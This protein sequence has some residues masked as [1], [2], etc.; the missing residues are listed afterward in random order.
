MYYEIKQYVLS[1]KQCQI[2]KNDAHKHNVPLKPLP[3]EGIFKRIHIDLFGPLNK[4]N[5]YKYV[6]LVV[7]S[8]TKWPEAFP[9]RTLTG[10]E[11]AKILYNEIICRWGAPY[12]LL[13]DRGTNFLSSIVVEVCKLFSISK[14]K[15]SSWHPETNATAERRMSTLAQTLRMYI[16]KHQTNWPDLLPSIMA[17]MRATPCVSSTLFSPY[18][19]LLGEEMRLPLDVDL[20]PNRTLP[21]NVLDR[22][23]NITSQFRV[24]R[25]L[26]KQNIKRAQEQN[27]KYHDRNAVEPKFHLGDQVLLRN[28]RKQKG[29]NPKLQAKKIGPYYIADV[30]SDNNTYLIRDCATHKQRRSRVNAKLLSKFIDENIRD[31]LPPADYD[32]ISESENDEDDNDDDLENESLNNDHNVDDATN[33]HDNN[34]QQNNIE[35][36]KQSIDDQPS[37]STDP[38]HEYQPANSQKSTTIDQS[39]PPS[40]TLH[41]IHKCTSYKGKKWYFVKFVNEQ[42]SKW[43]TEDVLPVDD[44]RKFHIN[45]TQKGKSK[46][47]HNRK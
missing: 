30:N 1:C 47:K 46:K 35:N 17:A 20:I 12:S 21:Q 5:G 33:N 8:F 3:C 23:E 41:K 16:N 9:V 45:K 42:K 24:T 26:A 40:N 38:K 27:K 4:V 10:E 31:I 36:Q 22:L 11:I 28:M 18:K 39:T 6:L 14:Y 25:D 19:L 2:N 37:T 32:N 13:S 44:V 29:L 34:S 7:D 15:T 43:V